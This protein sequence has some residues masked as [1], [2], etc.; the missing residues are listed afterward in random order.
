MTKMRKKSVFKHFPRRECKFQQL[1]TFCMLVG[2]F[3][4]YMSLE[5]QI[6]KL[7]IIY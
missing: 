5:F 1:E 3:T 2:Y 4:K 7:K 6:H